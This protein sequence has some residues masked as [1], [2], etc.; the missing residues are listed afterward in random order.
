MVLTISAKTDERQTSHAL[1][2]VMIERV[3]T[4]EADARRFLDVCE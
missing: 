3:N 2:E 4:F 1:I